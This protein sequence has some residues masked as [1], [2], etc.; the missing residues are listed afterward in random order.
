MDKLVRNT[1]ENHGKILRSMSS[2]FFSPEYAACLCLDNVVISVSIFSF[3]LSPGD[4]LQVVVVN[5][6]YGS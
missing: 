2:L 6:P 3:F 4:Y 1:I 5:K